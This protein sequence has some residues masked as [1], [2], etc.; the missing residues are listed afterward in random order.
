MLEDGNHCCRLLVDF[1]PTFGSRGGFGVGAG[2][3]WKVPIPQVGGGG[4]GDNACHEQE[5][6]PG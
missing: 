6:K 2:R 1:C 5:R 4:G 3:R